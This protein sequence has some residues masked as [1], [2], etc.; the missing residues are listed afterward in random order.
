MFHVLSV[1]GWQ[2]SLLERA[3]SGESIKDTKIVGHELHGLTRIV[4][5]WLAKAHSFVRYLRFVRIGEIRVSLL[6]LSVFER[7]APVGALKG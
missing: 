5:H 3:K 4:G 7:F 1:A 6:P 2:S